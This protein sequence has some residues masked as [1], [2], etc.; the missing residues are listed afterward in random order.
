[1]LRLVF[2]LQV[3]L[4]ETQQIWCLLQASEPRRSRKYPDLKELEVQLETVR[5][6]KLNK[7]R[8]KRK[9][10]D[11]SGSDDGGKKKHSKG[12]KEVKM[13]TTKLRKKSKVDSMATAVTGTEEEEEGDEGEEQEDCSA[14]PSCLRPTGK[15][16]G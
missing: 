3:S 10:D 15:E 8:K 14:N 4:D 2:I 5:E 13:T 1:M 9:L 12:K 7:A 11:G 16:V 6:E